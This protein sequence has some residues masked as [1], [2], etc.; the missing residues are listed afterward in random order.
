M[1]FV[2]NVEDNTFREK[3]S[4]KYL[5]FF[6]WKNYFKLYDGLLGL[7]LSIIRLE[8]SPPPIRAAPGSTRTC[9]KH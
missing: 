4:I 2:L 5:F 7:V 6:F 3:K 8:E 9:Q 1:V